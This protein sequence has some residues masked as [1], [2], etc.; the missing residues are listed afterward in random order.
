[1]SSSTVRTTNILLMGAPEVGKAWLVRKLAG[2]E[3]DARLEYRP[4]PRA[5]VRT[6]IDPTMGVW[7]LTGAMTLA[8]PHIAPQYCRRIRARGVILMACAEN[9]ASVQLLPRML[10]NIRDNFPTLPV[11][12]LVNITDE[13]TRTSAAMEH[14]ADI[15]RLRETTPN[16]EIWHIRLSALEGGRL[17]RCTDFSEFYGGDPEHLSTGGLSMNL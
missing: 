2:T 7:T 17:R 5:V 13:N 12:V 1:M 14:N 6:E 11:R 15:L 16:V 10:E 8:H 9:V 4:S 3:P